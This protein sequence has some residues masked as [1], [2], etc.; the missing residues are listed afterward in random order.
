MP[1]C[2][3]GCASAAISMRIGL[4]PGTCRHHRPPI[5]H[6]RLGAAQLLG[7]RT[8]GTHIAPHPL[9]RRMRLLRCPAGRASQPE[10]VLRLRQFPHLRGR[11][12]AG[13][14]GTGGGG[15]AFAAS[16]LSHGWRQ[17]AH[18]PAA[19]THG[20]PLGARAYGGHLA[21]TVAHEG[22]GGQP[23]RQ[24]HYRRGHHQRLAGPHH[25]GIVHPAGAGG[26]RFH[27]VHSPRNAPLPHHRTHPDGTPR[28]AVR[29]GRGALLLVLGAG[30]PGGLPLHRH[31]HPPIL[32]EEGV[33]PPHPRVMLHRHGQAQGG[34]GHLRLFQA[35]AGA[36]PHTVRLH[37]F[38]HQPALLRDTC[39]DGR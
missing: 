16:H 39:R 37:G 29:R 27:P 18:L 6:A 19:R 31:L 9:P 21:P 32:P 3:P 36:G 1:T 22:P 5:H 20:G 34:A 8:G 15:R 12:V 14:G 28:G 2:R 17:V 35:D 11:A 33:Q 30:L 26:G 38:A 25:P 24:R 13:A 10:D 7:G 4:R 23:G